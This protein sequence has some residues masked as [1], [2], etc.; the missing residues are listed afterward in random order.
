[1]PST[2]MDRCVYCGKNLEANEHHV[3]L[4]GSRLIGDRKLT[5]QELTEV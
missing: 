5:Y 1:M 2:D 3:H 4:A